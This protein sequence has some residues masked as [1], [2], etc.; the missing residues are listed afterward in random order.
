MRT[1]KIFLTVK[2]SQIMG[3]AISAMLLLNSKLQIS[4]PLI[5]LIDKLEWSYVVLSHDLHSY[6]PDLS[7]SLLFSF[8]TFIQMHDLIWSV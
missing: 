2:Q 5:F 7:A 4:I 3:D 8:S 6:S 1:S